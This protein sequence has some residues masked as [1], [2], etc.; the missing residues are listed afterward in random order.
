MALIFYYTGNLLF[1]TALTIILI[2][3]IC[4][5]NP[6]DHRSV[7]FQRLM[8]AGLLWAGFDLLMEVS[9]Y[10]LPPETGFRLY[11]L[12][13]FMFLL[14][15]AMA[16]Q[17]V[18]SLVRKLT[19][20]EKTLILLPYVILYL[21]ILIFPEWST[22]DTFGIEG[23]VTGSLPPWNTVFKAFSIGAPV[24]CV[25]F[26]LFRSAGE[27]DPVVRK[28][29][30]LLSLGG[31]LFMTGIMA[32]QIA[33]QIMPGLPWF[34]N[35]STVFLGVTA[36]FSLKKYGRVLSGQGLFET[37]VKI[38]PSGICHVRDMKLIWANPSMQALL[39]ARVQEIDDIR[40]L[41]PED[42][43]GAL[44]KETLVRGIL[45]GTLVSQR[46]YIETG[47]FEK[48]ACLVSSAPL[49]KERPDQGMLMILTDVSEEERV[50][51]E[52]SDLNK[53][54]EKM[55]HTDSLTRIANR[56]QFDRVLENE[57]QRSMRQNRFLS[58]VILDVDFFKNYNDFYGH[59]AGDQVL[60]QVGTAIQAPLNRPG[61]L[62]CRIGGEEFA[63]ILP[64]T[65]LEGAVLLTE[66]VRRQ[67]R[68]L[69][70]EHRES[71]ASDLVTV[72]AGIACTS[73]FEGLTPGGFIRQADQ[74][75]YQAK[76]NGRN[77]IEISKKGTFKK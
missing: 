20:R 27:A 47:A 21:A 52:L 42:Q 41:F 40:D 63:L 19:A 55:A 72:S 13:S 44:D 46:A 30:Q 15:P 59:P 53:K 57:W 67:I 7:I 65:P 37:I 18:L 61:D 39:D 17:L 25:I 36:F 31:V 54:L 16:I 70:I 22:A 69:K 71:D 58:L 23:G 43:P 38:S 29:K 49:E 51:K 77:R 76:K 66:R 73:E 74:A 75:L 50:R 8:Y 24:L 32:S 12:L 6:K 48:Q 1:Q 60:R 9:R 26:V 62:A 64:E 11:G 34:A 68:S 4:R 35:F 14:Y 3:L 33:K 56:R 5:Y 45:Q 28:E 10:F 2:S